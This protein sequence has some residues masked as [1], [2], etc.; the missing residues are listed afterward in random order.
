MCSRGGSAWISSSPWM[1]PDASG[2]GLE[3]GGSLDTP[4]SGPGDSAAGGSAR[5]AGGGVASGPPAPSSSSSSLAPAWPL[6][7][8]L[9]FSEGGQVEGG[10]GVQESPS[11]L[12]P[13]SVP[14]EAPSPPRGFRWIRWWRT[15]L[16]FSVKVLSQV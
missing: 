13:S 15:R 5:G 6:P 11:S 1:K 16:C 4:P 7:H 3:A 14:A 9:S 8:S 12:A 2:A 10:V